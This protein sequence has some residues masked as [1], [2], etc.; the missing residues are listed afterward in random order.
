MRADDSFEVSKEVHNNNRS[1]LDAL[2]PQWQP[3]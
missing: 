3:Y 1:N 2:L